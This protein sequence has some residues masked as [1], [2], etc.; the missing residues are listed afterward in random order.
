MILQNF[1]EKDFQNL[2]SFMQP[3]WEETYGDILPKEQIHF[4]L[5]KYFSPAAI[6]HFRNLGYQYRKIDDVGVLVFVEQ[7]ECIYIDK[8]YLLPSARGKGYPA[9]IFDEL[10]SYKKDILLNVNQGNA[11]AVACYLKNGFI[12]DSKQ[13]IDLGNGMINYDYVMRKQ[14][15]VVS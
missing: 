4:L 1:T 3:L 12:I 2:H 13:T 11:R 10:A 5:K 15:S 9:L 6:V 8:L 14:C 7:E